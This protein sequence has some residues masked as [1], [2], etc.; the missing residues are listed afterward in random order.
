MINNY[1]YITVIAQKIL[2][3]VIHSWRK[4]EANSIYCIFLKADFLI[5]K[6]KKGLTN[7]KII[8]IFLKCL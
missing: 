8:N 4:D 5:I 3:N 2:N 1:M 7:I 6:A